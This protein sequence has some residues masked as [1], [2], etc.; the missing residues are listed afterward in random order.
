MREAAMRTNTEPAKADRGALPQ[1]LAGFEPDDIR[2][3]FSGAPLIY[4]PSAEGFVLLAIFD[5][6]SEP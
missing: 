6:N 1:T 5:I 4:R 2:D 3:P